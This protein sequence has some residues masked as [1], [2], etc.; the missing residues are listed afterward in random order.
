MYTQEMYMLPIGQV[1]PR[2]YKSLFF[3][4]FWLLRGKDYISISKIYYYM[5]TVNIVDLDP[6]DSHHTISH[7][8]DPSN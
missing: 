8:M 7:I 5:G 2:L 4:S 6:V 1:I 3:W